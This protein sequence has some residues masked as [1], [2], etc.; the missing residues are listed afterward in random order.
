MN[1]LIVKKSDGS[2]IDFLKG[3]NHFNGTLNTDFE[4]RYCE[5]NKDTTNSSEV[6]DWNEAE[7]LT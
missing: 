5:C 2:K 6:P 4:A 7:V 3:K 1:T